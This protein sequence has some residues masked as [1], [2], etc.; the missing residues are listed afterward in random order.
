MTKGKTASV[1]GIR[2]DERKEHAP[3]MHVGVNG[4]KSR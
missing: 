3:N 2:I 1:R 4:E